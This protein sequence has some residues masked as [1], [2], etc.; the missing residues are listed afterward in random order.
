MIKIINTFGTELTKNNYDSDKM[1]TDAEDV[2]FTLGCYKLNLPIGD[3]VECMHFCV[4]RIY[5][6]GF[7]GVHKPIPELLNKS[8]EI[9]KIY[10]EKTNRFIFKNKLGKIDQKT[11]I[12]F[13]SQFDKNGFYVD[14]G[15]HDGIS[16]NNTL[17]FEKNNN[18]TG[19]NIEPIKSV[20][21]KL[22][23]NRP[24]NI[25]LN[26]AVCNN[27]GETEFLCNT[28]ATEMIS[29]IKSSFDPR[30]FQ[31]LQNENKQM[32]STTEVIKVNTKKLETI[33]DE[34]NISHINY[35]SIDVEGAEFEVIKSINFEKVFIDIIE[36]ENN[37]DDVSIPIIKY[38]ENKNYAIIH[39]SLD[40]FMIN[41][42]SIFNNLSAIHMIYQNPL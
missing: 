25:N 13:Y 38:L 10:C 17:Y 18:W 1:Q 15:A 7:F 33:F 23:S 9:S 35:L 28:G 31:R 21:N 26:Y 30:H 5:V 40:I 27:N 20:F 22:V 41:N 14:V 11:E 4:N 24:N 34:N 19:I 16:I 8:S 36:F 32:G 42:K 12:Q 3:T 37:Y 2:Y 6:N 39:R 29:G